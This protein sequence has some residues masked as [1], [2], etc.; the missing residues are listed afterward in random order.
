MTEKKTEKA[1]AMEEA[2]NFLCGYRMCMEML[3]LNRYE[4]HRTRC[5]TC[6][7]EST[8]ALRTSLLK[9]DEAY[10]Q[11][12]MYEIEALMGELKNGREKL[13]LHYHYLRGLS[14]ERAAALLGVSRRTGYRLHE[15]GLCMVAYRL[16]KYRKK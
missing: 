4:R 6:D 14:V 3:G 13:I 9:G 1:T 7:E 16:A 12:Q 11:M 8:E 15:R 10:W 2:K 5:E